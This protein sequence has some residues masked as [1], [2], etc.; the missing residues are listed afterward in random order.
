MTKIILLVQITTTCTQLTEEVDESASKAADITDV[1]AST[2][3]R[4]SLRRTLRSSAKLKT[5]DSE[6]GQGQ[7][8]GSKQGKQVKSPQV[9]VLLVMQESGT[10]LALLMLYSSC[11]ACASN[12]PSCMSKVTISQSRACSNFPRAYLHSNSKTCITILPV[13]SKPYLLGHGFMSSVRGSC[14]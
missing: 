7:I 3:K 9:R 11:H 6:Q 1:S 10:C 8:Q 13:I 14:V 4:P 5:Q 12:V 2:A